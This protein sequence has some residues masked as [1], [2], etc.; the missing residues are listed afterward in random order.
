MDKIHKNSSSRSDITFEKCNILCILFTDD[1][2]LLSSNKSDLQYA[3]NWFSDTC[4]DAG[5]KISMA[6]TEIMCCQ[7]T[8]SS[9]FSKQMEYLSSRWRSLSILESHF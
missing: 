9:V 6:K 1:L 8:L 4:L 7:G 2:V 3:L 5:I